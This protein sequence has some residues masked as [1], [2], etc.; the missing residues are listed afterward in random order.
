MEV[1]HVYQSGQLPT[2]IGISGYTCE[3]VAVIHTPSTKL[4]LDNEWN[5][6]D[7][8]VI[9]DGSLLQHNVALSLS[10]CKPSK[11]HSWRV[12]HTADLMPLHSVGG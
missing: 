10:C 11:A 2:I 6:T 5:I 9:V 3:V 7:C 4:S 12:V 8:E 1:R